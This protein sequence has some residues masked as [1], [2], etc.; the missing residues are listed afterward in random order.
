MLYFSNALFH[1]FQL[2]QHQTLQR[3]H[4][5]YA[6]TFMLFSVIA[7]SIF[8]DSF[9]VTT[10]ILPMLESLLVTWKNADLILNSICLKELFVCSRS[11]KK[12]F[13][14]LHIYVRS[15][16]LSVIICSLFLA[17]EFKYALYD[18]LLMSLCSYFKREFQKVLTFHQTFL[19]R[20]QFHKSLFIDFISQRSVVDLNELRVRKDIKRTALV[21]KNH[22][23]LMKSI[24]KCLMGKLPNKIKYNKKDTN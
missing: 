19:C 14:S 21:S 12:T 18:F 4:K 9:N 7:A 24:S 3:I 10:N 1:I 23:T 20:M 8:Y 17:I 6:K 5:V 11:K 15:N 22:Q 13:F 16:L 2:N